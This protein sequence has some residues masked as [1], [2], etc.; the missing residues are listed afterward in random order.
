VALSFNRTVP[1][2]VPSKE[3]LGNR[4]ARAEKQLLGKGH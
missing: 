1:S 4:R 3:L 2:E